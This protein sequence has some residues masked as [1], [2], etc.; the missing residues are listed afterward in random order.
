[1]SKP[2]IHATSSVKRYGGVPEDYLPI[3][4]MMDSSKAALADVRHRAVF[5]SAFGIFIIEKIF[6]TY[7]TNSDGKKVSV[8]DI[9][10][11]HVMEDLGTIPTLEQWMSNLP[12]SE[13]MSGKRKREPGRK[14]VPFDTD[15][16]K[17]EML[18]D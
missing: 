18:I 7:I 4:D 3:H 14:F 13:W 2:L 17:K 11:D 5:H 6:G 15:E 12:L 10:E 8:R 16:L 9:A 1:M